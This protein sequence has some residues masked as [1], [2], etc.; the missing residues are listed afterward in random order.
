LGCFFSFRFIYFALLNETKRVKK[1]KKSFNLKNLLFCS[2]V[3]L[4]VFIF[5][6]LNNPNVFSIKRV[7]LQVIHT[8]YWLSRKS[9]EFGIALDYYFDINNPSNHSNRSLSSLSNSSLIASQNKKPTHLPSGSYYSSSSSSSAA[10]YSS[11]FSNSSLNQYSTSSTSSAYS[12]LTSQVSLPN[13]NNNNSSLSVIVSNSKNSL[14]KSFNSTKNNNSNNTTTNSGS[15][16]N[17]LLRKKYNQNGSIAITQNSNEINSKKELISLSKN[18]NSNFIDKDEVHLAIDAKCDTL[19]NHLPSSQHID[20]AR[21]SDS[22]STTNSPLSSSNSSNSPTSPNQQSITT[23]SSTNLTSQSIPTRYIDRRVSTSVIQSDPYKFN[24]NYSEAGQKLAKKA[25]EQLKTVE[26]CKELSVNAA[27]AAGTN[28]L[29]GSRTTSRRNSELLMNEN[30]S[31]VSDDWQN[32]SFPID[33]FILHLN[34]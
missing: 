29:S 1:R 4:F 17:S 12:S 34:S 5:C 6:L 25:Q 28:S 3:L 22:P 24:V 21:S 7:V 31:L 10:S 15:N 2:L 9:S 14:P 32:V 27:G 11:S 23:T 26:K 20:D 30:G 18:M 8:I 33:F 13:H 16:N 19:Q